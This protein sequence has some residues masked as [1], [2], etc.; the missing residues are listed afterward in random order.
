MRYKA[1]VSPFV[2]RR[3]GYACLQGSGVELEQ[4][5]TVLT[6]QCHV[7][8]FGQP[9]TYGVQLSVAVPPGSAAFLQPPSENPLAL[10]CGLTVPR[11]RN[12]VIYV[13]DASDHIRSLSSTLSLRLHD[14]V[15]HMNICSFDDPAPLAPKMR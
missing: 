12:P 6:M 14:A 5:G 15:K 13:N 9:G 2:P 4:S 10:F 7:T 8:A 3:V 11:K 1:F